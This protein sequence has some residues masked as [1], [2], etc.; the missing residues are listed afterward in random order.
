MGSAALGD[1]AVGARWHHQPL[2]LQRHKFL[3][4][5]LSFRVVVK[6]VLL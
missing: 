1:S 5:R 3:G 4:V 6:S 2:V